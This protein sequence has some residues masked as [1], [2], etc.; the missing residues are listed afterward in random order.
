MRLGETRHGIL[1]PEERLE[2]DLRERHE[3][4][5]NVDMTRGAAGR[6]DEG[7]AAVIASEDIDDERRVAIFDRRENNS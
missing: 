5:G 6:D 3:H 2:L 4:G 1:S 7:A